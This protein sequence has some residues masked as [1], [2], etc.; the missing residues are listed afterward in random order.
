MHKANIEFINFVKS[1]SLTKLGQWSKTLMC[2]IIH[3]DGT[4]SISENGNWIKQHYLQ[5]LRD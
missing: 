1:R 5:F 2:P 3:F 4:K